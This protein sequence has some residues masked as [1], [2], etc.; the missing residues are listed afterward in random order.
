MYRVKSGLKCT[1][2]SKKGYVVLSLV[3]IFLYR[4]IEKMNSKIEEVVFRNH[5]YIEKL[6]LLILY[7][8]NVLKEREG[9]IRNS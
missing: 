5:F 7:V 8:V 6:D 3:M 4:E 1:G 9:S 2:N